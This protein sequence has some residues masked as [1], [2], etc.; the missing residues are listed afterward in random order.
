M[1][2]AMR[3]DQ[4]LASCAHPPRVLANS[5]IAEL[6]GRDC[7]YPFDEKHWR[8]VASRL[9]PDKLK[10]EFVGTGVEP[11]DSWSRDELIEQ[12]VN[13]KRIAH[14]KKAAEN[15]EARRLESA[16]EFNTSAARLIPA[17]RSC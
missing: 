6:V 15:K 14:D 5:P 10:E 12:L 17:P 9:K 7:N 16:S 3:R 2:S 13:A 8:K 11:Q 4:I 1:P